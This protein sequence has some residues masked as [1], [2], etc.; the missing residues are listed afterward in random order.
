MWNLKY[1][2]KEPVYEIDSDRDIKSRLVLAKGTEA[3]GG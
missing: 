3:G 1:D 2:P